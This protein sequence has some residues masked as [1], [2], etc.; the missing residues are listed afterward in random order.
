MSQKQ[1]GFGFGSKTDKQEIASGLPSKFG[2]VP[3]VRFFNS[4]NIAQKLNMS[5][6]LLVALTL[7]VVLLGAIGRQRASNNITLTNEVRVPSALTAAQA[8]ISLLEMLANLRGY[9]VFGESQSIDDFYLAQQSFEASLVQMEQLSQDA[10]GVATSER[11]VELTILYDTWSDLP[12]TLFELHDNPRQNQPGLQIYYTE[13]RPLSVII[14]SELSE[15]IVLQ[16]KREASLEQSDLLNSMMSFQ[17]S[18]DSMMTNLQAYATVG[19]LNFKA[20][21]T[22]RLPIN[23]ATWEVLHQA[24]DELTLEQQN[25][26]DAIAAAR[27]ELFDLPFDIFSV[28][29]SDRAYEDLYI[30]RTEAEPLA[31]SMLLLLNEITAEQEALLKE[32]LDK[33]QTGLIQTQISTSIAAFL[34]LIIAVLLA[35]FFKDTIAGSVQRLTTTAERIASGDMDARATVESTDEIGRLARM[36]NLMTSYLQET[37]SS[38]EKQTAQAEL[39]N[40]AKSD[41]LANISHEFRTPL[42][43]ILGYVQILNRYEHLTPKQ[44]QS[45][46][47]VGENAEHLLTLINDLLDLSKIEAGKITLV[48]S[49]FRFNRF[50]R[51]LASM[52]QIRA[53][54]KE[55]IMFFFDKLSDLPS[56][57]HADEKRMRQIL[58][59]LLGNAVK[60]T[61]A[62]EIHFRVKVLKEGRT[63]D[64]YSLAKIR[65]EVADTGVGI[66]PEQLDRI[67]LPFEQVGQK[68]HR[69]EGTGLGLTITRNLV[70]VMG[71]EL[72]VESCYQQGSTFIVELTLPV[73]WERESLEHSTDWIIGYEGHKR[74]ILIVDD[75]ASNRALFMDLLEP[76]GF[77]LMEAENG[78]FA[79]SKTALMNPDLIFMDLKMPDMDGFETVRQIRAKSTKDDSRIKNTKIIAASVNAY[80]SEIERSLAVGCDDFLSKPIEMNKL[81][82]LLET[83]LELTWIYREATSAKE[84]VVNQS[85]E[86]ASLSIPQEE[87]DILYDL[88]MKG[89]LLRL[90]QYSF[91]LEEL[92]DEYKPFAERLRNL[93][94]A[95]DEDKIM[96]LIKSQMN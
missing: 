1:S 67:F 12:E 73:I 23:T 91:K 88:A 75:S 24:K 15:M 64:A 62:G 45:I 28:T 59:N 95:F 49:D 81:F 72:T 9:L 38:L 20:G 50:L 68:H 37:I 2:R 22:T 16:R 27:D 66:V 10:N 57:V 3:G 21:Y 80:E 8:Q 54:Q 44:T 4:L 53:Q 76:L 83:H 86:L 65:F 7:L 93:V 56:I 77:E 69:A 55:K 25:N 33:S 94:E 29:E 71:G 32:D 30:F 58:M 39:A 19:D 26:L 36:F 70:D 52:F 42:N 96:V 6:G 89:E 5:F 18:F 78:R 90:K 47:I 51:S 35:L 40:R 92:G 60:F 43:G 87:V 31:N 79:I 48:P 85:A 82:Q 11:L 46:H 41:F 13:V 34:V 61:D 17:N 14:S 74:K 63:S 84:D